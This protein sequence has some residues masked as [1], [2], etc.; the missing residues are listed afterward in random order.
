MYDAPKPP[1][2]LNTFGKRLWKDLYPQ[3][4]DLGRIDSTDLGIFEA[5]CHHYGLYRESW[6][7]IYNPIDPESGKRYR[8]TLEQYFQGRNSQ[9]QP[10]LTVMR[11]S[12]KEFEKLQAEFGL[13]PLSRKKTGT[14]TDKNSDSP[15]M[16]YVRAMN[17]RMKR[18][19]V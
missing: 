16:E 1:S 3:L 9:T 10:E 13:S 6:R 15:M 5:L 19:A 12:L 14:F 2:H 17:E 8:Q 18:R 7:A 11:E 4:A